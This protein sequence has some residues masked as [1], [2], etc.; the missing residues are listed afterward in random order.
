MICIK[1]LVKFK[2]KGG[3]SV[4]V[5]D[6]CLY[7]V[8]VPTDKIIAKIGKSIGYKPEI[9]L[10]RERRATQHSH[11]LVESNVRLIKP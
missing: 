1:Y 7:G 5:G 10:L 8:H 6:S 3:I 2:H 11:K 9:E 4:V